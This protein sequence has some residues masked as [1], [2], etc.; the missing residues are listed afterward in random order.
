MKIQKANKYEQNFIIQINV[1]KC[2]VFLKEQ[3]LNI[4]Y[5]YSTSESVLATTKN[6]IIIEKKNQDK[7]TLKENV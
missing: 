7:F 5:L 1:N 3:R 2:T 4:E 6:Y